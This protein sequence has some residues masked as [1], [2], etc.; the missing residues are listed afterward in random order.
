M[1]LINRNSWRTWRKK[2]LTVDGYMLDR[3]LDKIK[4]L[5]GIEKIDDTKSLLD[6]DGNLPDDIT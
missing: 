4:K 1:L 2:C 3:I 6:A 5:A